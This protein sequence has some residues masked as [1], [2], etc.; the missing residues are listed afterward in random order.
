MSSKYPSIRQIRAS[1]PPEKR[2]DAYWSRFVLRPVSFPIT[3]V[4]LRL[5]F[6][7]NQVSY[8]SAIIALIAATFMCFDSRSLVITGAILFNF[9]AVLDC[10]DGNIARTRGKTTKYGDFVDAFAGY[11]AYGCVFLAAGVAAKH[12]ISFAPSFLSHV[13]FVLVGAVA[14]ISNMTMRTIYQHFRTVYGKR[15]MDTGTPARSLDSNLGITGLLMPAVL[16]GVIFN[17]LHW[18][19]IFYALFH[20]GAFII[21]SIKLA[22]TVE[23]AIRE[24]G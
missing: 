4:F 5:G 2:F 21:V 15:I 8:F 17:Q 14:S 18:V 11:V 16:I 6:S 9:W 20:S 22:I 1:L 7:A 13:D 3:W 12:S 10:V 23:D 24:E 19:I